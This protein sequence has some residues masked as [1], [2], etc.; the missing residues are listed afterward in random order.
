MVEEV[1]DNEEE[2]EVR[3]VDD[4]VVE[5]PDLIA[6]LLEMSSCSFCP[7]VFV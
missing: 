4:V 5:V 1:E 6:K 7:I 3:A 2:V